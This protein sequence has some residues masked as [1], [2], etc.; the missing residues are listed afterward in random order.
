MNN[1]YVLNQNLELQGV[2]DEYESVIWRPAYCEI[3]N[4]EIYMSASDKAIALLRPNWYV[5]RSTDISV[6]NGVT[7]YKKVMV[8]KNIQLTTDVEDGNYL[9]VTGRELKFLLHQR[10]VW[11]RYII[12]DSVE[13]ALRR[14]IGANA[15]EPVEPTR[16]IPNMQFADPKGYPEQIEI[17]VSN[18]Q[19]DEAVIDICKTYG[20]GWDIYIKGGKLTVDIY[21][22]VDHSYS[23]TKNA[24]VIF[25]DNFDNL[26][27]TEYLYESENYANMTLV[28]GEG[29]GNDRI[30]SY[31]NND[32]SG[33]ERYETFTD[34]RDI[35]QNLDSEDEAI[36]YEDYLL[37]LDERGKENL[38]DKT[39]TEGFNGEVISDMTFK[40]GV[41]FFIGDI[42]TVINEYGIEKNVRV[43]SAIESEGEDGVKLLPQFS[44]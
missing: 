35:S 20:Y 8:I 13:Y 36:S 3:G 42:V 1:I 22:G 30:Y 15:V 43:L 12:R 23:Q 2:I 19:L 18:K 33:L 5:V 16:T 27:E 9:C 21:K 17:Q 37:L 34:A 31:V 24:Y 32:V 25:S 41:D 26:F 40:Y 11:G 38:S 28:G 4:F 29:E 7:V 44:M 14:L 10:I 39:I 6:V